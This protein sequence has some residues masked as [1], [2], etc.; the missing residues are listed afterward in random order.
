MSKK[1][2]IVASK[3]NTN[4]QVAANKSKQKQKQVEATTNEQATQSQQVATTSN[5]NASRRLI[6]VTM[7]AQS[8]TSVVKAIRNHDK[9]AHLSSHDVEL[10]AKRLAS[11]S[12]FKRTTITTAYSDAMNEKYNKVQAS[13]SNDNVKQILATL[14]VA[15]KEEAKAK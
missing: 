13:L 10:V 4:K 1:I 9:L 6:R 14:E 3:K 2:I 12:D 11:S 8:L 15:K 7:F 5:V